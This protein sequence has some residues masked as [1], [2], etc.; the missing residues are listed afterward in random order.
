[1]IDLNQAKRIRRYRI[2]AIKNRIIK[3]LNKNI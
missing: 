3:F 2:R 1:M